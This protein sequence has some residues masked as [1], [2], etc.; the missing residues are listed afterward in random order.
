[1]SFQQKTDLDS[2]TYRFVF[3]TDNNKHFR[4]LRGITIKCWIS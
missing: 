2:Y 1:M 3:V 4:Y